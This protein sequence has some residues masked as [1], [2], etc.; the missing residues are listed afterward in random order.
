MDPYGAVVAAAGAAA[1]AIAAVAGFGV[2][3]VLTP[4]LGTAIGLKLAIAAASIP[5]V[6]AT[7]MRLWMMRADVDRRVLFTF[8]VAS[9]A[10]GLAGAALQSV[11]ASPVLVAVFATLLVAAGLGAITGWSGRVRFGRR[12][13]WMGGALSG[14]LGGLVGNQGGVRSAA[15]LGFSVPKEAFVATSTAVALVVDAVRVPVYLATQGGELVAHA[16]LI[17]LATAGALAGTVAGIRVL[18][19]APESV[20]RPAVGALLV[21]LAVFTIATSR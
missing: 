6:A 13:A 5:H 4:L 2:G 15:M 20:F 8:G 3:S 11:L 21:A 1:G 17:A 16:G 9:A 18:R 19:R 14:L 12:G 7:A 10:G